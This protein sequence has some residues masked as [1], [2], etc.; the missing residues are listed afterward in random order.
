MLV[1]YVKDLNT[2]EKFEFAAS[3]LKEVLMMLKLRKG[4]EFTEKLMQTNYKFILFDSAGK[5]EP[6]G[7]IP[8]V[9]F[10]EI[11]D[12]DTLIIFPELKG[13]VSAAVVAGVIGVAATSATAVIVAAVINI[14][15]SIAISF[16]ISLI[17]PTP[18]FSSDPSQAQLKQSSLFNGAPLIREQGGSVPLVFGNPFAGGVLISSGVSTEDVI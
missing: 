1:N 15:I 4:G 6:I 18:E 13:E 12:Y 9:L 5:L 17:S 16:I 11:K 7:L 14:V 3:S 8:E 10:S 2:V